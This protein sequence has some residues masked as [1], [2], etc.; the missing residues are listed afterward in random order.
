MAIVTCLCFLLC[1]LSFDYR[2]KKVYVDLLIYAML[3]LVVLYLIYTFIVSSSE[4]T[5]YRMITMSLVVLYITLIFSMCR[6]LFI[7]P[8]LVDGLVRGGLYLIACTLMIIGMKRWLNYTKSFEHR[9]IH[10]NMTDDHT[11]LLN[12]R[13]IIDFFNNNAE[14]IDEDGYLTFVLLDINNFKSIND[15]YGYVVSDQVLYEFSG[16]LRRQFRHD[17]QIGRWSGDQFALILKAS[18]WDAGEMI[19]DMHQQL[20]KHIFDYQNNQIKL[21]VSVGLTQFQPDE[22]F[23]EQIFSRADEVLRKMKKTPNR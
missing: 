16:F 5:G 6:A 17:A 1:H 19:E 21:E 13:A 8:S 2:I 4:K 14:I 11:G 7:V 22:S 9:L 18:K 15:D 23:L 10:Q 12:K 3:S 20:N